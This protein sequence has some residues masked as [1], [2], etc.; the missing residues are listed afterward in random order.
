M[1][2]LLKDQNKSIIGFADPKAHMQAIYICKAVTRTA[3][4]LVCS[5]VVDEYQME[6]EEVL[7]TCFLFEYEEALAPTPEVME[8]IRDRAFANLSA[9]IRAKFP[10]SPEE[11]AKNGIV[12]RINYTDASYHPDDDSFRIM[13]W[14]RYIEKKNKESVP[15]MASRIFLILDS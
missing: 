7:K 12:L 5:K 8:P 14:I 1:E 9:K 2:P 13:I 11:R 10:E 15:L 6:A 3:N 4:M